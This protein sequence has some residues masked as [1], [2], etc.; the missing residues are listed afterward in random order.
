M[1]GDCYRR[2]YYIDDAGSYWSWN[3]LCSNEIES[4]WDVRV[5]ILVYLVRVLLPVT[6]LYNYEYVQ[7][8]EDLLR[9]LQ[10][11]VARVKKK[12]EAFLPPTSNHQRCLLLSS[13]SIVWQLQYFQGLA[14]I[15][16]EIN[17]Q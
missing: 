2:S 12:Q 16:A 15:T 10:V 13:K 4:K 3:Y 8:G 9:D 17:T 14:P 11:E 1:I 6:V 5:S 7:V